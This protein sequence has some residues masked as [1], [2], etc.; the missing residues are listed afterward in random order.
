M[1]AEPWGT[2]HFK[3]PFRVMRRIISLAI[4]L[5]PYIY[6]YIY[7]TAVVMK[8]QGETHISMHYDELNKKEFSGI[9]T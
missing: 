6:I 3:R 8:K 7:I 4:F 9:L 5:L 1:P 2:Y